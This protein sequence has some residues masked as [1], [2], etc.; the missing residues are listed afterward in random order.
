MKLQQP[1]A[2]RDPDVVGIERALHRKQPLA[3]LVALADADGLIRRAVEFLAHLHFDQRALFLDD[4]DELEPVRE[5]AQLARHE[6]PDAA[7][8]EYPQAQR[9]A[10]R[11]VDAEIVE[12]LAHVE[13]GLSGGDDSDLGIAGR[14][15]RWSG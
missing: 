14:P 3:G 10:A 2:D 4:D 7:D 8:L 12:R 5:F 11:L 6:R 9:V 1:L 13:I 15:K